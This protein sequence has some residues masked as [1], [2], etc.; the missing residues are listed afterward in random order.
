M[1][2]SHNHFLETGQPIVLGLT[3]PEIGP[4][5]YDRAAARGDYAGE[6]RWQ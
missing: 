5:D 3:V 4:S 1:Y 2:W 6:R